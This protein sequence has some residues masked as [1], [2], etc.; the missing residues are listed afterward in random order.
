MLLDLVTSTSDR[1]A[2][3]ILG[4]SCNGPC[5]HLL[6]IIHNTNAI[7]HMTLKANTFQTCGVMIDSGMTNRD[8]TMEVL[9]DVG[10]FRVA[11]PQLR[12]SRVTHWVPQSLL[13]EEELEEVPRVRDKKEG[14]RARINMCSNWGKLIVNESCWHV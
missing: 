11:R 2:G 3:T 10:G 14:M 1:S 9:A 4:S 8:V 6:D 5:R 13:D 12:C 7:V